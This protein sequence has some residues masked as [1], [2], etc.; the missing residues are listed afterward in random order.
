MID[1]PTI[2]EALKSFLQ[3]DLSISIDGKVVREG[4]LILVALKTFYIN[5]KLSSRDDPSKLVLY[6]LPFPFDSQIEANKLTLSYILDDFVKK[7]V[8]ITHSLMI[9]NA[10]KPAKLLNTRVVIS[11]H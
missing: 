11:A 8:D 9:F 1:V 2:E 7:D 5:L 10:K 6:E 4:R 3:K